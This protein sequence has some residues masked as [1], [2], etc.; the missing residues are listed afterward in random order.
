V[1]AVLLVEGKPDLN[2]VGIL[3]VVGGALA[4]LAEPAHEPLGEESTHRRGDE[5]G[6]DP[7]VEET[8]DARDRVVRVQRAE[9]Q[10]TGEGAADR[11]LRRLEVT[12]FPDHD[13][14]RVA[15]ENAA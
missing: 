13:D 5:E 9:D 4:L 1:N 12:H 15:A 2:E 6:L 10:V 11:D 3:E 8:G 7:H 14:V